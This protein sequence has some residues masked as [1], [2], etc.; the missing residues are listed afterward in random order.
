M[1]TK[2]VRSGNFLS[3]MKNTL[4]S[5]VPLH[6]AKGFWISLVS[7]EARFKTFRD[8]LFSFS[9]YYVEGDFFYFFQIPL[10]AGDINIL[11]SNPN[12]IAIYNLQLPLSVILISPWINL[13]CNTNAYKTR[14]PLDPILTKQ[15]LS[16]YAQYY[17]GNNGSLADPS[18]LSF[19]NFPPTFLLA[20][21]NE[22]LY[23][24][25]KN[26]YNDIKLIQHHTTF[27]A[28]ENQTHVWLLTDISSDKS[29]EA[30]QDVSDFINNH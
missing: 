27:K 23:D 7:V 12:H 4:G 20:G 16:E 1:V 2:G 21:T 17:I 26:F 15:Y 13:K 8:E 30:L 18:E 3:L 19:S 28:Y 11:L 5:N 10:L 22:V 9:G 29:K 24:D 25:A 6:A 14:Q